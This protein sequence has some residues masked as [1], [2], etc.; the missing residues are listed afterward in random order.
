M[1]CIILSILFFVRLCKDNN[2]FSEQDIFLL[3]PPPFSHPR[4]HARQFV[5]HEARL[6]IDAHVAAVLI[7]PGRNLHKTVFGTGV[8]ALAT[9]FVAV[10][11]AVVHHSMMGSCSIS[12]RRPI[13]RSFGLMNADTMTAPSRAARSTASRWRSKKG[14]SERWQMS[15]SLRSADSRALQ[16]MYESRGLGEESAEVSVCCMG[17]RGRRERRICSRR[18]WS[19]A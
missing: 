3:F 2:N 9:G 15:G 13:S 8:E 18:S 16:P 17:I 10:G 11:K 14:A 6:A 4:N 5:H 7:V 1:V 12:N 19:W